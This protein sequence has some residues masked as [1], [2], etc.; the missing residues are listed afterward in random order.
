MILFSGMSIFLWIPTAGK[1]QYPH[2]LGPADISDL[3]TR[4]IFPNVCVQ[5]HSFEGESHTWS[6]WKSSVEDTNF[7][8]SVFVDRPTKAQ[9]Y[10]GTTWTSVIFKDSTFKTT[11]P[12]MKAVKFE[13]TSFID[14]VFDNCTFL[15]DIHFANFGF[16]L[17][18]FKNSSFHAHVFAELGSIHTLQF[19]GCSF[20]AEDGSVGKKG[21]GNVGFSQVFAQ[22]VIFLDSNLMSELRIEQSSFESLEIKNST[23]EKLT[24]HE[25]VSDGNEPEKRTELNETVFRD[26]AFKDGMYCDYTKFH[27]LDMQRVHVENT[28]DLSS[29]EIERLV[30]IDISSLQAESNSRF[31]LSDSK[32]NGEVIFNVST[33]SGSYANTE[34]LKGMYM[35]DFSLEKSHFELKGAIFSSEK[36]NGECCTESCVPRKCSCD[37]SL[38]PLSCPV[39]D[40][41]VN[42]NV[43]G[44]C[45]PARAELLVVTSDGRTVATKMSDI[46]H[47]DMVLFD[48]SLPPSQVFFFGHRTAQSASYVTLACQAANTNATKAAYSLNISPDHLLPV[49]GRGLIAAGDVRIGDGL[50]AEDGSPLVVVGREMVRMEGMYA[51]TTF[52]G[53]LIV[54]G[55]RVSCYTS[56]LPVWFAHAALS[57]IRALFK[58]GKLGAALS[59]RIDFLHEKSFGHVVNAIT[60]GSTS[61]NFLYWP[62]QILKLLHF[63]TSSVPLLHNDGLSS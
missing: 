63:V 43:K 58:A 20:S 28:I 40:S 29:S 57:P 61:E 52:S 27:G 60:R 8:S 4:G 35:E 33:K 55:I 48:R 22:R 51:P 18:H 21:E 7:T 5:E 15:V 38:T 54:N 62:L 13:Q 53:R 10:L 12:L 19:S 2:C 42:R 3:G 46:E 34:F 23:L 41:S 31:D 50:L 39:G 49:N 24:C 17:V 36:V 47:G 1:I 16:N 26:I 59:R 30:A 11:D 56:V 44:S 32:V 14:V 37:V 45:F 6:F 9:N 25:E